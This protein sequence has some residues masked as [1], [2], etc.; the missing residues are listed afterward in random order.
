MRVTDMAWEDGFVIW[1]LRTFRHPG[2]PKRIERRLR[3]KIAPQERTTVHSP[4]LACRWWERHLRRKVR[5]VCDLGRGI[6]CRL[7]QWDSCFSVTRPVL[8]SANTHCLFLG[9]C[10]RSRGDRH[11]VELI[12]AGQRPINT[13]LNRREGF[14]IHAY[15]TARETRGVISLR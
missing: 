1:V 15:E 8:Q 3:Q 4:C 6:S 11:A 14:A 12:R 2:I 7:R 5:S 10:V 13:L 9:G